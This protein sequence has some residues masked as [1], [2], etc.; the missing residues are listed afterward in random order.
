MTLIPEIK[1]I[2]L[3]E[4]EEA[5]AA[6]GYKWNS[7][8]GTR[9][10]LGGAAVGNRVEIPAYIECKQPMICYATIDSIG[11]DYDLADCCVI[12]VFVCL[13][14]LTTQSEINQALA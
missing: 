9:H 1:L 11:E 3:P 8:A 14:C 7:I 4:T 6:I 5:K 2:P 10:K 12:N 13:N